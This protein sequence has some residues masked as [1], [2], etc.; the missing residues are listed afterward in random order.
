MIERY[1]MEAMKHLWTNAHKYQTWWQVELAIIKAYVIKGIIPKQD[2]DNIC[3]HA[4]INEKRISELETT[5]HHD[6]IAFTRQISETL[7]DERKWVHYGLTSTDVVDTANSLLI[8]QANDLIEQSFI[9]FIS[10]L[11]KMALAYEFTPCIGR[12]HGIH[13]EITSFGLKWALY[14]DEAMR[15]FDRFKQVRKEIEVGKLSGA[16]GNFAN[17]SPEIEALA[18]EE[19][20][21]KPALIATQVLSRDRHAHYLMV[22]ALMASGIEK[23]AMEIRH[24]SITEIAEVQEFFDENQKGSSAMPHKKNPITSENICGLTRMMRSYLQVALE[25]NALWHERDI[26]HS[27]TERLILPDATG[28]IYYMLERYRLALSKLQIFP[29]KM[30]ENINLTH[31]LVFSGKIVSLLIEKQ[32]SREQSYDF[33]QSA[34]QEAMQTNHPLIDILWEKGIN[35]W[36][37][38]E[39]LQNCFMVKPYLENIPIIYKRLNLGDHHE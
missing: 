15:N 10:Q 5:L 18:C 33:V 27:S 20:Q 34:S 1:Q 2:Y 35:K 39:E 12:T 16:V 37:S 23:I 30:E 26:S 25:N 4:Q 8:K 7:G 17:I 19:L 32:L 28:I 3:L 13:A 9:K 11:K 6:V 21:L 14:Y 24:L 22:L 36:V 29:K 38:Q 31:G